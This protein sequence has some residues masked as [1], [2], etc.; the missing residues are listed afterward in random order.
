MKPGPRR[1][2]SRCVV[3]SKKSNSRARVAL[4]FE[5]RTTTTVLVQRNPKATRLGKSKDLRESVKGLEGWA[6]S[7]RRKAY[8]RLGR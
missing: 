2:K 4:Q 5:A 1:W 7:F 6:M 3:R 8:M